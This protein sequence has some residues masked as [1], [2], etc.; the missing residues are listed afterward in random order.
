MFIMIY[1]KKNVYYDYIYGLKYL[2][3]LLYF[4]KLLE[5]SVTYGSYK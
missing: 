3:L 5:I 4:Q 1:P 2:E